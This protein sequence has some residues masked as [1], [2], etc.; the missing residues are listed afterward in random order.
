[1]WSLTVFWV[2]HRFQCRLRRRLRLELWDGRRKRRLRPLQLIALGSDAGAMASRYNAPSLRMAKLESGLDNSPMYDDAAFDNTS[3]LMQLYDVG[4]S[5]LVVAEMRHLA[6]LATATSGGADGA[7][8]AAAGRLLEARAAELGAAV[9]AE[10]WSAQLGAFANK[11]ANGSFS[12]RVSPTPTC[13]L[14]TS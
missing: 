11:H 9:H 13:G 12:T 5:S 6:A 14:P 2:G 8:R 1:M 10:L 7:A 4:M 3:K